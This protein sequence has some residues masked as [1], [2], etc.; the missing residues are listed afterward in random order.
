M[1]DVG[2]MYIWKD[3]VFVCVTA[4]ANIS[5]RKGRVC[6]RACVYVLATPA[7]VPVSEAIVGSGKGISF[8]HELVI[9]NLRGA[10]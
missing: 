6:L 10:L 2:E 3:I 9:R 7:G 1:G 8:P 4:F 5:N